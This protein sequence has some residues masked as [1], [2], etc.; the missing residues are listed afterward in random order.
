MQ[1]Y[2]GDL[3]KFTDKLKPENTPTPEGL[4][5]AVGFANFNSMKKT[6]EDPDIPEESRHYMLTG[7]SVI[8]EI[9][10]KAGM[11][12]QANPSFTKFIMSAQLGITEKTEVHS[13]SDTKITITWQDAPQT[14]TEADIIELDR[15]ESALPESMQLPTSTLV[16]PSILDIM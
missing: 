4:A 10:T 15:L 1:S 8:A 14:M 12:D 11:F 13:I 3:G 2:F 9:L 7:C 16:E 5:R 6:I